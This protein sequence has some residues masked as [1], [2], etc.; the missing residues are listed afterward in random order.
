MDGCY[1]T[2]NIA[3]RIR[4]QLGREL[5]F[6]RIWRTVPERCRSDPTFE[7]VQPG[8][9]TLFQLASERGPN[10]LEDFLCMAAPNMHADDYG[11]VEGIAR[12]IS[13]RRIASLLR[14]SFSERSV[15]VLAVV[16]WSALLHHNLR[17]LENLGRD[18]IREAL[19]RNVLSKLGRTLRAHT[20]LF[21]ANPEAYE[22]G[23][24]LK[25]LRK[26]IDVSGPTANLVREIQRQLHGEDKLLACITRV[27]GVDFCTYRKPRYGCTMCAYLSNDDQQHDQHMRTVHGFPM[28]VTPYGKSELITDHEYN[29]TG[30][31][32][33]FLR[34]PY[35]DH[36]PWF[37]SGAWRSIIIPKSRYPPLLSLIGGAERTGSTALISIYDWFLTVTSDASQ[38]AEPAKEWARQYNHPRMSLEE[39][40]ALPLVERIIMSGAAVT[41]CLL[42]GPASFYT[43]LRR[44]R[45]WCSLITAYESET[46]CVSTVIP[47]KLYLGSSLVRKDRL[48][49][50]DAATASR[51]LSW[52]LESYGINDILEIS[53]EEADH[54]SFWFGGTTSSP[55]NIKRLKCKDCQGNDAEWKRTVSEAADQVHLHLESSPHR[56][57]FVHCVE[58]VIRSPTVC[59]VYLVRYAGMTVDQALRHIR[60]VRPCH[61]IPE[62]V[63]LELVVS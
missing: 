53:E 26:F 41:E 14:T 12:E 44:D 61:R 37:D 43:L 27:T 40:L 7:C 2:R 36:V 47:G 50:A 19:M 21:A 57:I 4:R 35:M 38:L 34:H 49:E 25:C 8:G 54:D 16:A 15:D 24:A 28:H 29:P 30:P 52:S 42:G 1:G 48:R 62:A 22:T 33:L 13:G 31:H 10:V 55:P 60:D 3:D 23:D 9:P 17:L 32:Y 51:I 11:I 20:E 58:G 45:G 59:A 63:L 6:G 56:P 39:W 46:D 18:V 5:S